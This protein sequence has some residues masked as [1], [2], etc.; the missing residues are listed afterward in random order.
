MTPVAGHVILT[1]AAVTRIVATLVHIS[2]TSLAIPSRLAATG[3]VIDQV[4]ALSS[5]HAR[6]A[7]TLIDVLF[8]KSA[9]VSRFAPTLESIDLVHTL[10][11]VE[12]GVGLTLIS[13]E[14]ASVTVGSQ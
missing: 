8:T 4:S 12:T 3:E 10:S 11:L 1:R 5:M 9:S 14:L 13:I 6:V 2:L 7:Q